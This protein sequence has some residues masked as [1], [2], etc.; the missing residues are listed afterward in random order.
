MAIRFKQPQ[1]IEIEKLLLDEKNPRVPR[2]KQTL[3][4]DELTIYIAEAYSALTIAHSIASHQYFSSEPLI[5]IPAK[6]GEYKVV[7]GNRRLAALRLLLH[8]E[9]RVNLKSRKAWDELPIKNVPSK[10]PVVVVDKRRDVAPIIGYRHISGIEPWDSYAKSRYIA[11]QVES[12]LSFDET[13]EEVGESESAVRMNYRNYRIAEQA[14][15]LKIK[16]DALAAMKSGFGIFTRA[17]QDG[18]I[19]DF[20]GAPSPTKTTVSKSPIPTKKKD[21]LKEMV[22]FLFGSTAVLSDSRDIGKLGKAVAS[23]DGLKSL[24]QERNLEE[25]V[26]A[27]GGILERLMDRLSTAG[28]NLRSAKDDLPMYKKNKEVRNLIDEAA[29]GV[30]DLRNIK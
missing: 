12:G 30:D 23:P 26:V 11:D 25:A 19:R 15:K 14:E 5:A 9:L 3:S 24:R 7:E 1:E 16:P 27:S 8:K 2:E 6:N 4:Q 17:M 29:E 10:V 21:A 20:I 28:R 22:E 18:H 13:A